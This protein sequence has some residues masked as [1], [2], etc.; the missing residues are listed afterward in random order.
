[1]EK[2]KKEVTLLQVVGSVLAA[3]FGVQSSKNRERDFNN[4]NFSVFVAVGFA[5][6]FAVLGGIYLLV[7]YILP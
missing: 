4:G 7:S 5:V 2:Q 3:F 1:M 6:T